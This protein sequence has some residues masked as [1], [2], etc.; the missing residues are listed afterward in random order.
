MREQFSVTATLAMHHNQFNLLKDKRFFPICLAQLLQAFNDNAY[1]LAML[2]LISFHLASS[3]AVSSYYQALGTAVFIVPYLLFSA[4]FG[5]LSDKYHKVMLIRWVKA[6]EVLL[7][8][9]GSLAIW[10]DNIVM[11]MGVLFALGVHSAFFC[12]L[13]YALL[14]EHLNKDELIG[15]N[16][17]VETSLILA[18]LIGTMLGT[19]T[20]GSEHHLTAGKGLVSLLLIGCAVAGYLASLAI[21]NRSS[22][23]DDVVVNANVFKSTVDVTIDAMRD[24]KTA[25]AILGI[26]WFWLF[27]GALL[28]EIPNYV[29][30]TLHAKSSVFAFFLSLFTIGIAVGSLLVNRLLKGHVNTQFVPLALFGIT[31]FTIDFYFATPVA[32]TTGELLTLPA[33]LSES[34]NWQAC[35]DLFMLAVCGGV[36]TVLLYTVLQVR[37]DHRKMARVLAANNIL[38]AL[39]MILGSGVLTLMTH[40]GLSSPVKIL[41]LGMLNTIVAVYTC[42]LLP[43]DLLKSILSSTLRMLYKVKIEGLE[44]YH[45]AG[46]RTIIVANHVSFLDILFLAA[47]LPDKFVMAVN[48]FSAKRL[49]IRPFLSLVEAFKID[50]TNPMGMKSIIKLIRQGKKCII[51]PEGR[52]TVTGTIMK[53]YEGSAMVADKSGAELL[54]ICIHGAKYT[55]FSRLKGKVR[56]RWLPQVTISIQ[57][58]RQFILPKSGTLRERRAKAGMQLYKLM[59]DVMFESSDYQTTLFQSLINAKKVHGGR[60]P[61]LEDLKRVPISYNGLLAKSWILGKYIKK[62]TIRDEAVGVFL[63]TSAASVVS[64]FAL[65]LYHRIPAMLNYSMGAQSLLAT[66]RTADVKKV[67]T[68]HAFIEKAKLHEVIQ[69][70]ENSGIEVIYLEDLNLSIVAKLGGLIKSRFSDLLYR[71]DDCEEAAVI[72]FTSGSEGSPKGVVLSH[73]N[74]LANCYQLSA[75]VALNSKDIVFNA[76]PTFHSF[77]LTA[78]VILPVLSGIKT[79][80][81]PSPLHYRVVP[82]LVY[83][84]DATIM[85]GTNTFLTGYAR[86]AHPY[87]F[88]NIRYIFAGAE[89]LLQETRVKYQEEYGVRIFEG[90]GATETAPVLAANTPMQ[91]RVETTGTFLPCI[92][93]KIEHVPGIKEGGRLVV[94]GPNVMKGYMLADNPGELVPLKDGWYDTG[95]IVSID[96]DGFIRILGR[97]KRFAKIAGEM[98][99]LSYVETLVNQCW[100]EALH[101]VVSLPCERKGERLLLLT[102]YEHASKEELIKFFKWQGHSELALPREVQLLKD[103]PVLASGKIDYVTLNKQVSETLVVRRVEKDEE[104]EAEIA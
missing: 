12:P 45:K 79:F 18:I 95:D 49:W 15:A 80:C 83:D 19:L 10:L 33:F 21:P 78:G 55:P 77:G 104:L 91:Y 101:A 54:P 30:F 24:T 60:H 103:I 86:Y 14:P 76:M 11:M 13:K 23:N 42:K 63:P 90:Y 84:T 47:F 87:D 61:V 50:A 65:T 74:I 67:L 2:T 62:R 71:E 81:Y 82:E 56:L 29:Q 7:M 38:N 37:T 69:T 85:F 73:K 5:Q 32:G 31:I 16:A 17:L 34:E 26:S 44:N 20:M 48:T 64:F 51:F 35:F 28:A 9:A 94:K 75:K 97:A 102:D 22:V 25:L 46:E 36:F 4:T 8:A 1:K 89:K 27:G 57:P 88:Y 40:L 72:L 6:A 39:F 98:V 96:A 41:M 3:E 70:V 93:H 52:L 43:Y 58:P 59:T 99:S 68:A 66:I 53:V 92:E 100:P